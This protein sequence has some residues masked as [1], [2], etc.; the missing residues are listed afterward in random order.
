MAAAWSF[1]VPRWVDTGTRADVVQLRERRDQRSR[2]CR[3]WPLAGNLGDRPTRPPPILGS[4][5]DS[6][7]QKRPM[8]YSDPDEIIED[9][10][11]KQGFK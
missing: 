9:W 6:F 3:K 11:R 2:S 1:L 4:L 5:V 7:I 10:I 8:I